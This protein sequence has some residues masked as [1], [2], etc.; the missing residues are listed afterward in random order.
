MQ[1]QPTDKFQKTVKVFTE[2]ATGF[3]LY[4]CAFLKK[5]NHISPFPQEEYPMDKPS[6]DHV[7]HSHK[8]GD[9]QANMAADIQD[10]RVAW[11]LW[12]SKNPQDWDKALAIVDKNNE[13][14]HKYNKKQWNGAMDEV[15][16]E[17]EAK[18]VHQQSK[19]LRPHHRAA[20]KSDAADDGVIEI[21]DINALDD[22]NP[23]APLA[24][25]NT[26]IKHPGYAPDSRFAP[27]VP[28]SP[29]YDAVYNQPQPEFHGLDLGIVK[30]GYNDYPEGGSLVAG[31]NVGVAKTDV[32]LGTKTGVAAEFM[33]IDNSPIHART[34]A[35]VNLSKDGIRGDVGAGA[36]F[37]NLV[38][39]DADFDARVGR[40]TGVDGD[41]R[42]R[43]YPV[44]VQAEAGAG[45]GPDGVHAYTGA[46][47][48]AA[49]L[50]GVRTG[51]HFDLDNEDSS[52]GAGVGLRAGDHTLD[53]GPSIYTDR[54][55]TIRPDLQ[56]D[57]GSIDDETFYPTGTRRN[58]E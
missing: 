37:F 51:G 15:A 13:H 49:D 57:T 2:Q 6:P 35:F 8:H 40:N 58:R 11:D 34:D 44:D 53:F 25:A 41:V 33:P 55:S 20:A 28:N 39:G 1:S 12:N 48:D 45:V 27:E 9:N 23:A 43:V 50:V 46:N 42:G 36:N 14:K 52:V 32:E 5:D 56:L 30:L 7:K 26:R 4:P 19:T 38:N 54:N 21:K 10:A 31:V 17:A 18:K 24:D 47:T 3:Q 29:A 16:A 22:K